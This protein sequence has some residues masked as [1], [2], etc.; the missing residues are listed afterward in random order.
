[1]TTNS[2]RKRRTPSRLASEVK[3]SGCDSGN[4]ADLFCK[5]CERMFTSQKRL[6]NHLRDKHGIVSNGGGVGGGG[7]NGEDDNKKA[8]ASHAKNGDEIQPL[9]QVAAVAS[10]KR[11]SVLI[12]RPASSPLLSPIAKKQRSTLRAPAAVAAAQSSS[13]ATLLANFPKK[14]QQ[15]NEAAAVIA[16]KEQCEASLQAAIVFVN[17]VAAVDAAL[18]EACRVDD[19]VRAQLREKIAQELDGGYSLI[20]RLTVSSLPDKS[21]V[22]AKRA[23]LN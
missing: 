6:E 11:S 2:A 4:E 12:S 5:G 7:V 20:G 16:T 1:M 13:V 17:S 3:N 9:P 18:V 14:P 15:L 22:A 10:E 19:E 8:K 21:G 23:K